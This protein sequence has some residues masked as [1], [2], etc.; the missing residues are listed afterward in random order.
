MSIKLKFP[1]LPTNNITGQPV[2]LRFN[3]MQ[4][5]GI[6]PPHPQM[7]QPK[8][9]LEQSSSHPVSFNSMLVYSSHWEVW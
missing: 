4:C 3:A 1:N 8:T 9:L 6:Y 7:S 5:N 2:E